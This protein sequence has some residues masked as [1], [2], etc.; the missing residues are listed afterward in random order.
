MVTRIWLFLFLI[1]FTW[2]CTE[3]APDL[4]LRLGLASAPS[5]LDPRYATDATSARINRLLYSR[6]V[7]FAEDATPVPSLATWEVLTPIHYRFTFIEPRPTFPDGTEITA[8]DVK[9]TYVS[10]LDPKTSSPHRGLLANISRIVTSSE[11]TVDFSLT[12]PDPLFPGYVII[13]ILPANLIAINHPFHD[14]PVGSGPFFFHRRPD[15]TR[16]IL[17]RRQDGQ[18]VELIKIPDPTVRSLK[19]MA[20][21]IHLLQNDLPPELVTYL[22]AR[23]SLSLRQLQGSNFA[24][25]GFN[26]QD[27][28]VGQGLVRKAIAHAINR[29]QIIHFVLGGRARPAQGL[30]PPSHWIGTSQLT[31][32]LYD[33]SQARALL[34]QAGFNARHRPTLIYK[35]ST[36]PFRLRLATII[37]DQLQQVG[38]D[39]SIHSHDWGTFY[40]DIKTGRFQMYSLAW[41][42]LKTP[43]I[44]RQA[45]HS[46]SVPP[47]G[48]NRGHYG[49]PI[50]DRLIVE[51]ENTSERLQQ[52]KL[53]R[54]LQARLL[55]RLP[56]VPLWYEDHFV[57]STKAIEGYALHTDGNYD[58]LL[59]VQW[60]SSST[61]KTQVASQTAP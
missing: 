51:A 54:E 48:V 21:E 34:E 42:G 31:G 24:Y 40:G 55:D 50:T 19:L 43:D 25:L 39:V 47:L 10:V 61:T 18:L 30:F 44:F 12:H 4:T 1:L 53:Y 6:L 3:P 41:V 15:D 35:T 60:A 5:N 7:D 59:H 27:P 11:S 49:D 58:G 20:G 22:A 26:H 56:Y 57:L 36:D 52:Q 32:Y 28:V 29:E 16:L 9:A 23:P 45:F 8:E 46:Q 17:K 37:Q 14:Q 33:P 13:G 2:G 38:I